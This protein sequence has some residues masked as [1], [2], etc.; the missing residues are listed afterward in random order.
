LCDNAREHLPARDGWR[1][2][3]WS[4]PD[5]ADAQGRARHAKFVST[6]TDIDTR[7]RHLIPT[8]D[9]REVGP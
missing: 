9:D 1:H 5:P 8:L 3:H 7:V 2:T 6:A 4:V